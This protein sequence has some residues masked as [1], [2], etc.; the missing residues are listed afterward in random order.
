MK[1]VLLALFVVLWAVT[2][3]QSVEEFIQTNAIKIDSN[4]SVPSTSPVIFDCKLVMVGEMHGTQEPVGF[5]V[6][7]AESFAKKGK[8]VAVG[9]EIPNTAMGDF[10][11]F[12]SDSALRN[13]EWFSHENVDGRS[14]ESW[15]NALL[16]CA[17]NPDIDVFFFDQDSTCQIADRDSCMA[18]NVLAFMDVHPEHA[19]LT[20]SGNIHSRYAEFRG[21]E[22]MGSILVSD[23]I[24]FSAKDICSVSHYYEKGT[25]RNS[26]GNGVETYEVDSGQSVYGTA[27][28]YSNYILFHA[29]ND[30]GRMECLLYTTFVTAAA[31]LTN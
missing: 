14:S 24:R 21:A 31:D 28:D 1:N 12:P 23:T 26:R 25:M 3:G 2:F 16:A 30:L 18:N 5:T 6:S 22:T 27:V 9:F 11:M 8:P 17:L 13:T 15:F 19:V 20:I 29:S 10:L 4:L 7:L